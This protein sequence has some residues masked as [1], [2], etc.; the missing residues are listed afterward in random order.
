[1]IPVL[2]V[3]LY[4]SRFAPVPAESLELTPSPFVAETFGTGTLEARR[5]AIISPRTTGRLDKIHVDQGDRV[6]AGQLLV[7]LDHNEAQRRLDAANASHALAAATLVRIRTDEARAN[8]SLAL[9]RASYQ[10]ANTLSAQRDLSAAE[11]DKATEQLSLGEA[12]LARTRAAINEAEAGLAAAASQVALQEELLAQ[13]RLTAPFAGLIARRDRHPG[14]FVAPGT[15]ILH[16]VPPEE[17]WVSAWIDETASASLAVGQPARI[18]F[19][20][21]PDQPYI[22]S[23][24]RIGRETDR[25]TREFIVEIRLDRIPANWTLGQRAEVQIH[26]AG[27]PAALALPLSFIGYREGRPG[28]WVLRENRARWV[29]LTLGLRNTKTVAIAAGLV[30]GDIALRPTQAGRVLDGRRITRP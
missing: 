14:E 1:L 16:L 9:A 11:L 28:A 10:R 29:P 13:T 15:A 12:D 8:A 25:E 5:S 26:T 17:L 23:V 30:A 20:A 6:Q 24:E 18:V 27:S 19:R 21:E 22:G 4:R 7:E 3:A 2:A